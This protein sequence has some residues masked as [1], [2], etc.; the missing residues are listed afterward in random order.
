MIKY[1]VIFSLKSFEQIETIF[2]YCKRVSALFV[3]KSETQVINSNPFMPC[4]SLTCFVC[5]IYVCLLLMQSPLCQTF[6]KEY[7][8]SLNNTI[9]A[10]L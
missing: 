2:K 4:T 5:V 3:I 7:N 9:E 6:I 10:I 1:S 8:A